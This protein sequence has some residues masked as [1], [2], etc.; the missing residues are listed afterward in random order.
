LRLSRDD[1][2]IVNN[3]LNEV[4]HGP[5]A[6]DEAEFQIRIGQE[7]VKALDLLAASAKSWIRPP[8]RFDRLRLAC[9]R[10]LS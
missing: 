9:A 10:Q 2:L 7:R 3:A 1:L 4:L 6:I 8:R 5:D